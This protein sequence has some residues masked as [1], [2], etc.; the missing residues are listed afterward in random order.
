MSQ[1]PAN[2]TKEA[3]NYWARR[4]RLGLTRTQSMLSVGALADAE[5]LSTDTAGEAGEF[6]NAVKSYVESHNQSEGPQ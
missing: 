6:E 3:V 2:G 4:V 1:I 5:Q